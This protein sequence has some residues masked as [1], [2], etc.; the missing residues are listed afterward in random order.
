[1]EAY[2]YGYGKDRSTRE[3]EADVYGYGKVVE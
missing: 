3:V 1:M 2:V